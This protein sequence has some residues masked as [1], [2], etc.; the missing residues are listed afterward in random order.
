[1]R[2]PNNNVFLSLH[3]V[4]D[5]A[6]LHCDRS[7]SC[8]HGESAL[9]CPD[10]SLD[11]VLNCIP[12]LEDELL[13]A[14][15]IDCSSPVLHGN[16][17]NSAVDARTVVDV[18][19]KSEHSLSVQEQLVSPFHHWTIP[20]KPRGRAGTVR[21]RP[22]PHPVIVGATGYQF[23]HGSNGGP[24][25]PTE[26]RPV[27]A[28]ATGANQF[29]QG[30]NGG[31]RQPVNPRRGRR[32][33][34][35]DENEPRACSHCKS[36]DTPQWREGPLGRRTLCNACGLRYKMGREKLVPEYCPSTSPF[37]RDGKHSNRHSKVEKLRKKEERASMESS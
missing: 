16:P 27:I 3:D 31:R 22:W 30:S 32:P 1:M 26:P 33:G 19:P 25:Q 37:F 6:S 14:L 36:T 17:N 7:S 34:N 35:E 20:K 4:D 13:E 24:R 2:R 29:A 10:D 5:V 9:C 12:P 18:P 11:E 21:K 23:R 8:R 28:A 15:G